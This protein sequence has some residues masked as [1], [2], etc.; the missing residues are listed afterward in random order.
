[1]LERLWRKHIVE[2]HT[3]ENIMLHKTENSYLRT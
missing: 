1:M 2:K 3:I